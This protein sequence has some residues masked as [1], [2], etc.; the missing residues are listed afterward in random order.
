MFA[1]SE[2][3]LSRPTPSLELPTVRRLF[4]SRARLRSC[5]LLWFL[6]LQIGGWYVHYSQELAA[7]YPPNR[8]EARWHWIRYQDFSLSQRTIRRMCT[9]LWVMCPL[10]RW[11]VNGC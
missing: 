6:C 9:A 5:C 4:Q 2:A 8:R 3:R 1:N 7:E 11:D 10:S